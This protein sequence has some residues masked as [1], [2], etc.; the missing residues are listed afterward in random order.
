M[1][2]VRGF[3]MAWGMFC[4]IPCPYKEWRVEDRK[5]QVAMLPL[6]GAL[7]GVVLCFCWWLLS[8]IGC[9]GLLA[10]AFLTVFKRFQ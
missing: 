3:L 6:V 7:I 8:L 9:N 4:W 5:A 10:G 1:K 2:Y